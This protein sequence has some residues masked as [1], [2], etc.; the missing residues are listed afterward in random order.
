VIFKEKQWGVEQWELFILSLIA[1]LP[2]FLN[3]TLLIFR[4]AIL[5]HFELCLNVCDF[6][7][8]AHNHVEKFCAPF[9]CEVW[10]PRTWHVRFINMG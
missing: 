10:F 3:H 6:N 9:T 8:K 4:W 7:F 5:T 2:Q 1:R